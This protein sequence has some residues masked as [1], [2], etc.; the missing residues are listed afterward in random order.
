M[1]IQLKLSISPFCSIFD[2]FYQIFMHKYQHSGKIFLGGKG[3]NSHNYQP[4]S[5]FEWSARI[6]LLHIFFTIQIIHFT[7]NNRYI[8]G[9]IHFYILWI[10][11]PVLR[12]FYDIL[13]DSMNRRKIHF[14]KIAIYVFLKE[15]E[16]QDRKKWII[17]ILILRSV[18]SQ[19]KSNFLRILNPI[20]DWKSI[21]IWI[22]L[23][24]V[25]LK[26]SSLLIYET[27]NRGFIN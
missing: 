12:C 16:R 27:I 15:K 8:K 25:T 11:R 6:P 4:L 18:F 14:V 19:V 17:L 3:K 9:T 20:W 21:K 13:W 1:E 26:K 24:N 23:E 2:W 7:N 10:I 22:F 5:L